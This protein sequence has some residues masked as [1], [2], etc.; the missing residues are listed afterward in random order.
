MAIQNR[1]FEERAAMDY[2]QIVQSSSFQHLMREK[3]NLLCHSRCF[4]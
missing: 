4:S 2:S 3:K 1:S